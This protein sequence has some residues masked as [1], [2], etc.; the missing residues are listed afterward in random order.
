[1]KKYRTLVLNAGYQ[2]I[3][4][5]PEI[6]SIPAEDAVTRLCNETC[7]IVAEYDSYIKTPNHIIKWPAV[8]ARNRFDLGDLK[9]ILSAE[10]LYYRDHGMCAYCGKTLTLTSK[11][12]NS[13]T[14]DHIFPKSKG[15]LATWD[16]IVASC[17]MCNHTKSNELPVGKWKPKHVAYTPSYWELLKERKKFPIKIHHNSWLDFIGPWESEVR[18]VNNEKI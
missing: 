4:L 5:F 13:V 10:T 6:H 16:N 9:T 1:M 2:P 8:I 7:H 15:G 12:V 18:L 17:P 14:M 11:R 3:S